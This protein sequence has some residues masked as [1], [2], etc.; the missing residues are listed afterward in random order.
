M[1]DVYAFEQCPLRDL[2]H[3]VADRSAIVRHTFGALWPAAH[4]AERVELSDEGVTAWSLTG[5]TFLAWDDIATVRSGRTLQIRGSGG[6]IDVAPNL[7]GFEQI[8]RRVMA[9]G[10]LLAA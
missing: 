9:R 8:E 4:R 3:A 10:A 5:Q 6:R 1:P 7:P 2:T